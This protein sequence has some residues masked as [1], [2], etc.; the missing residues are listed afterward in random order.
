M[1]KRGSEIHLSGACA[2]TRALAFG[3]RP[4]ATF[5]ERAIGYNN[6]TKEIRWRNPIG[7]V[8]NAL[9]VK[10]EMTSPPTVTVWFHVMPS[11]PNYMC[12][13][14]QRVSAIESAG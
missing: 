4:P 5:D 3:A 7:D 12:Y 6:N 13:Q 8:G 2:C 1:G 14:T 10:V 9:L 11:H